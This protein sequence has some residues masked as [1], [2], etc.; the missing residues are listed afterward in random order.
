MADI[1]VY[2][3]DDGKKM[4]YE[5]LKTLRKRL[6]T[7]SASELS[8]IQIKIRIYNDLVS[9]DDLEKFRYREEQY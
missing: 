4:V 9:P 8:E 7:C 1:K 6:E 3:T 2:I 5:E